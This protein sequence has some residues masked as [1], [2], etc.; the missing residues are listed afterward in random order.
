MF[1]IFLITYDT[2]NHPFFQLFIYL[3]IG[4]EAV[5]LSLIYLQSNQRLKPTLCDG[6][7]MMISLSD[8]KTTVTNFRV[9]LNS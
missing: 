7:I 6:G 3:F 8:S 9:T 5:K 2:Y 1:A 4:L